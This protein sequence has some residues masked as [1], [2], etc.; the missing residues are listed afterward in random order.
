M[1]FG[2]ILGITL[3]VRSI[4]NPQKVVRCKIHRPWF[5]TSSCQILKPKNQLKGISEAL[6]VWWPYITLKEAVKGDMVTI[7]FPK[8][9]AKACCL[10]AVS[11]NYVATQLISNYLICIHKNNLAQSNLCWRRCIWRWCMIMAL[12]G[13]QL[14]WNIAW[15]KKVPKKVFC[16]FCKKFE[17]L[18]WP[19][20]CAK[21]LWKNRVTT[22]KRYPHF[23]VLQFLRKIR[24]M[25]MATIFW[26]DNFFENWVHYS[27]EIPYGSKILSKFL[28]LTRFLRYK[29]FCV[30]QFLRKI[31]KF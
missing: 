6:L 23:Y 2:K 26:R 9:E 12:W 29:H 1:R 28:Y 16:N 22:Q 27:A 11:S 24:K 4:K 17:N 3:V 14:N 18:K 19:S 25:N 21:I 7:L 20:F 31:W 10:L 15:N 8:K 5:L 13:I 30:L